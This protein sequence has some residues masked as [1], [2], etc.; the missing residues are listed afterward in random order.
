MF[1]ILPELLQPLRYS[2]KSLWVLRVGDYRIIYKIE[3]NTIAI[4]KIG[5]RKEVYQGILTRLPF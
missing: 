1:Y 5:H 3:G 4:L 2:L